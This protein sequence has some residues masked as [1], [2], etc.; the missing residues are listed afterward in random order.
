M[1]NFSLDNP[2]AI[3]FIKEHGEELLPGFEKNTRIQLVNILLKA[4]DEGWSYNRTAQVISNQLPN[5]KFEQAAQIA[6]SVIGNAYEESNMII[7]RDM[8]SAGLQMVKFWDTVGDGHVCDK[9]KQNEKVGWISLNSPF[10]TGH[11][12]PLAHDGCRCNMKTKRFGS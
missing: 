9:C 12:R 5:I 2:R 8:Q 10:P 7:A 4:M 1:I 11:Q 3:I 6:N